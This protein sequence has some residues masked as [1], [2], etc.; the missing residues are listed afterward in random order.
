MIE[1]DY[2][3]QH[4]DKGGCL[5]EWN[6]HSPSVGIFLDDNETFNVLYMFYCDTLLVQCK[7]CNDTFL[8][9]IKGDGSN[10]V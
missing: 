10:G 9:Q 5:H 8:A 3:W 6:R 2:Q 4:I 1:K 7:S